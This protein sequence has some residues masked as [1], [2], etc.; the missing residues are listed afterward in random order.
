MATVTV[1][2]RAGAGAGA[3]AGPGPGPEALFGASPLAPA[4]CPPVARPWRGCHRRAGSHGMTR[5]GCKHAW[6]PCANVAGGAGRRASLA[7]SMCATCSRGHRPLSSKCADPSC[8]L[9]P[10]MPVVQHTEGAARQL[11]GNA[12][13]MVV[14]L[15]AA[16]REGCPA[17]RSRQPGQ[18]CPRARCAGPLRS[19]WRACALSRPDPGG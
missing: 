13:S 14:A 17:S 1:T 4:C 7:L 16:L 6:G 8:S 3:G 11:A 10:S 2:A 9:I 12:V 18:M 5:A 19:P 15:S